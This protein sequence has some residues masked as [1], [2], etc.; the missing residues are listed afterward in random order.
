MKQGGE[1]QTAE[2]KKWEKQE[3]HEKRTEQKEQTTRDAATQTCYTFPQHTN[4]KFHLF[5]ENTVLSK[6]QETAAKWVRWDYVE[7][8]R[9]A[10]SW[11]KLKSWLLLRAYR[12]QPRPK[13][14]VGWSYHKPWDGRCHS[15]V[16]PNFPFLPQWTMFMLP[17]KQAEIS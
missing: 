3:K 16:L 17:Q 8:L 11:E 14:H 1:Q 2:T 6:H 15:L 12:W 10:L 7:W 5:K 13:S 4:Q 9:R